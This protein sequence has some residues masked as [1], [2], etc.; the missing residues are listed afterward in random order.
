ML[1]LWCYVIIPE[2]WSLVT[3]SLTYFWRIGLDG[4]L[5]KQ[6]QILKFFGTTL[7]RFCYNTPGTA[8]GGY[9]VVVL[10]NGEYLL[11]IS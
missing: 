9:N 2:N 5:W 8:T 6:V 3:I 11:L 1:W 4:S 7:I 10:S